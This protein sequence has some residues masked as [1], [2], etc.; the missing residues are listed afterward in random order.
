MSHRRDVGCMRELLVD[1]ALDT[2]DKMSE[3]GS[4]ARNEPLP[5]KG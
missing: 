1:L 4:R 2:I 3:Q 5:R